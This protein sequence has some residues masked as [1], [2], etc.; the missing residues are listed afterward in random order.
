M[1]VVGTDRGQLIFAQLLAAQQATEHLAFVACSVLDVEQRIEVMAGFLDEGL[2]RQ[3]G[4]LQ[5]GVDE[6]LA[7]R[8]VI[9]C[10]GP[11]KHIGFDVANRRQPGEIALER[12]LTQ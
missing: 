12:A 8:G 6:D 11:A 9:G 7:G 10:V 4:P 2:G 1:I 5:I 3:I